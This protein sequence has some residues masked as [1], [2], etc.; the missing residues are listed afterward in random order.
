MERRKEVKSLEKNAHC[1]NIENVLQPDKRGSIK[2]MG[3]VSVCLSLAYSLPNGWYRPLVGSIVLPAHAQT[4]TIVSFT[5]TFSVDCSDPFGPNT[6]D[7]RI[8]DFDDSVRPFLDLI[9][10]QFDSL[11]GSRIRVETY[12]SDMGVSK[13]NLGVDRAFTTE[14][15]TLD[16]ERDCTSGAI[17]EITNTLTDTVF[18]S[19][20]GNAYSGSASFSSANGVLTVVL[21]FTLLQT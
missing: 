11:P 6:A 20:S 10:G 4:S 21:T 1:E 14:S 8:S 2:K 3:A 15:L 19:D 18:L 16:I 9:T 13:F 17:T 12:P 5:E 7:Y